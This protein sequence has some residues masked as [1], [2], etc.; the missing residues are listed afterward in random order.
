MQSVPAS[1][2]K[3]LMIN[4]YKTSMVYIIRLF[5]CVVKLLLREILQHR[6]G[7]KVSRSRSQ[8]ET[9][10]RQQ[11][12]HDSHDDDASFIAPQLDFVLH[13]NDFLE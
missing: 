5:D 10:R 1:F 11:E 8:I 7:K 12:I 3:Q 13:H 6:M 2:Q 4:S 9:V